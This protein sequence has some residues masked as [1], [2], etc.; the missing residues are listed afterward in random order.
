MLVGY[1]LP[2][3]S[4]LDLTLW[5]VSYVLMYQAQIVYQIFIA[6]WALLYTTV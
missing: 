1:I 3:T 4:G 6:I 2:T 5:E